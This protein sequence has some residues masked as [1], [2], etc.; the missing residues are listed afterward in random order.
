MSDSR[1]EDDFRDAVRA[2]IDMHDQLTEASK[3]LRGIRKKKAE[4]A[5]VILQ[6]MQRNE[7]AECT[8][9]DGKLMR[10]QAKRLEPLKK[11]H[12][13][14]ELTK[15]V[16]DSRAEDILVNIFSKRAVAEKD[17]LKRTRKRSSAAEGGSEAA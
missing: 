8:L 7:I 12:I 10:R 1:A 3:Q 6:Y 15:A 9:K 13:M 16:G 4:L 5:E 14:A 11:E 17:T 2:Y